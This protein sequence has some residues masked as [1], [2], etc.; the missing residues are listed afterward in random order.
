MSRVLPPR[1]WSPD[2]LKLD[3]M[4]IRNEYPNAFVCY[5]GEGEVKRPPVSIWLA[6]WAV[7]LA[8]PLHQRHG[9]RVR[10][11]VGNMQ[12]PY[13][14]LQ[15]R[16]SLLTGWHFD[17]GTTPMDPDV[18]TLCPEEPLIVKT[19]HALRTHLS[20]RNLDHQSL[21][22]S[23]D[24]APELIGIV[25]DPTTGTHVNGS[26][27]AFDGQESHIDI[28]P[29]S[30]ARVALV[31]DTASSN[32]ALGYAIPP[33]TWEMQVMIIANERRL[34]APRLPLIV[35]AGSVVSEGDDRE[36][37]QHAHRAAQRSESLVVMD[38]PLRV[39]SQ[40]KSTSDDHELA[41]DA[42]NV[43]VVGR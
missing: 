7:D 13:R 37:A 19:G 12:F 34:L 31:V 10:L 28:A 9:W 22:L 15:G 38:L 42:K 3:L 16:E 23:F 24:G 6:A 18:I 1:R 36:H 21:R 11:V 43:D 26:F 2:A 14:R 33:G 40:S 17:E 4:K 25:I 27:R 39:A 32:P 29:N 30:G 8:E 35:T 41:W 20:V 5:P